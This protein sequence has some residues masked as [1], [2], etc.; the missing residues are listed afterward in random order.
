ME[1]TETKCIVCKRVLD[2]ENFGEPELRMTTHYARSYTC[3]DCRESYSVR[4]RGGLL[5]DN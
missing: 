5:S 4:R 2:V 1:L 3:N